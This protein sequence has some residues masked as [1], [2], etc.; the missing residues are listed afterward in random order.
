MSEPA[1]S[2]HCRDC[3]ATVDAD[4]RELTA[5]WAHT[6]EAGSRAYASGRMVYQCPK[7][8]PGGPMTKEKRR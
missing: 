1:K 6:W 4:R 7:C 3:R 5:D 2:W 8:R